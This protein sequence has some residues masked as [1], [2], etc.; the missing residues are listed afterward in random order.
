MANY[1][2]SYTGAQI[3]SA[4]GRAN[5][6]DVT[7]GTVAASKAVVVDSNK[8]VTGF[9]NITGTGTA[10][11]ANFV[12]TGDIDIGD[13]SG[14][15]VTI[16]ASVDSNIVPSADDTYDL[17]GSSAQWKDLYVDGTAYIDA[18]DFN[19][20]AITSTGAELNLIDGGTARGTTAVATGDGILINDAGTM[21]MTN[22]DTVSTYFA[23]HNVG[24]GNIVT[25]GALNSGSITSGFGTIDNGTSGIRTNTFTAETSIIPDA[26]GGADIGSTSAE[27][28]DV[29]IADDKKIKFGNDQDFTIEYDEDG[30]DIAQFAGADIGMN[31]KYLLNEQGRQDHVANTMPAPYYRFDGSDDYIDTGETFQTTFQSS[32]SVV[33]V[34]SNADGQP[35][36]DNVAWGADDS[37]SANRCFLTSPKSTGK[38]DFLYKDGTTQAIARTASAVWGDGYNAPKVIACVATA[39]TD[40]KIYVDGVLQSLD[41]TYDGDASSL[42]FANYTSSSN[43]YLGARN[44]NGSADLTVDGNVYKVQLWNKALT[45][46]EVKELYSGGSVPFKY[47]GANQ[48][49]LASGY[50]FTSGWATS[51]ATVVDANT[52]RTN[53]S[54]TGSVRKDFG[55]KGKRT[56][57]R[58]AGT[59]PSNTTVQVVGV[60]TLTNHSGN[61]T[62]TFDSTF[63]FLNVDTGY[64]IRCIN[65]VGSTQDTDI[66]AF[67]VTE[68]GAVAEYDGSGVGASRWDDKSGNDLHGTVSGATVEN[69]PADADSGLTYEEGTWDAVVTDGTNPM[70]MNGSYDTGYYTKVGNL[71][72]VSGEFL[73]TSLGSASGDIRITGLPFTVANNQAART[74]GAAVYGNGF[75]ITAGHTV[76]CFSQAGST[77]II[78]NVWD[79]TTG[80]TVMQASE[81]TADGNIVIGFSYRAA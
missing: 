43:V 21:R 73:T 31:G 24:G 27:W 62:G 6:T 5:S 58:V 29:F 64:R 3:D 37:G 78:L 25:T 45:A 71:V 8:D 61:L 63:E 7:A 44:A 15:T 47:K 77:Y 11:F 50:D 9:R 22:V 57:I 18:I 53:A 67:T 81:W 52:F 59:T 28:G 10:T 34:L 49:D 55:T 12:G 70:T 65:T 68:I 13:A 38:L 14:D 51:S 66:T 17:G 40:L 72:T 20:T 36:A 41:V 60:D 23:S 80:T 76:S 39:D 69:A 19:G 26:S 74:G 48:T 16:T 75:A 1:N 4:V 42:T 30:S 35:A 46:T 54:A 33:A 79:A 32:F 2:S 56:R